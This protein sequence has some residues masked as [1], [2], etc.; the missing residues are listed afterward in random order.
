M[1][2]KGGSGTQKKGAVG[3]S[4]FLFSI[5]LPS[6]LI[7]DFS[8]RQRSRRRRGR[9]SSSPLATAFSHRSAKSPVRL[10]FFFRRSFSSRSLVPPSL[11][12]TIPS[13]LTD[14]SFALPAP[15]SAS[16]SPPSASPSPPPP[17]PGSD[18]AILLSFLG[19]S[20]RWL[21][22]F[23]HWRLKKSYPDVARNFANVVKAAE[24]QGLVV[25]GRAVRAA[26]DWIAVPGAVGGRLRGRR[27]T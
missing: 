4:K 26:Q 18:F 19:T 13:F 21:V 23:V 22:A 2:R 12:T 1:T 20:D 25:V 16:P 27:I 8:Q 11:L 7:L 10:F 6:F 17:S 24:K 3:T 9:S 14:S 15:P 5:S